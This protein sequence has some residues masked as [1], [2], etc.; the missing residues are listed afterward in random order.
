MKKAR[1]SKHSLCVCGF[2]ILADHIKLGQIYSVDLDVGYK[3]TIKCGGCKRHYRVNMVAVIRAD[4][5]IDLPSFIPR[6]ALTIV[7]DR[8]V[9]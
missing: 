6:E 1:Y 8:H 7:Y 4:D 9:Q 5:Q 2:P 3:A